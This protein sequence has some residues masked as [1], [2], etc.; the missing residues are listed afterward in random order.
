MPN[1]EGK[2]DFFKKVVNKEIVTTTMPV[3]LKFPGCSDKVRDCKKVGHF[4]QK[5]L[6]NVEL[7][8]RIRTQRVA[9]VT[10]V[11]VPDLMSFPSGSGNSDMAEKQEDTMEDLMKMMCCLVTR[12]TDDPEDLVPFK[13]VFKKFGHDEKFGV[14]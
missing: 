1:A 3:C 14:Q 7:N 5:C 12:T 11:P 2:F 4:V 10:Q 13:K 8:T 9:A 6:L